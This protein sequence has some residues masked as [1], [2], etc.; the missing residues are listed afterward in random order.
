[1]KVLVT[2]SQGQLGFDVLRE[3]HSRRI[4]CQGVD[5][6]DFDITDAAA[7]DAY[8]QDYAPDVV[9]HCAAYTAV[10]RAEEDADT[11]FKV[12]Y[13]GTD[14]LAAWCGGND[15]T[16]IY[17][18]T[19]YVFSSDDQQPI[20]V[21]ARLHPLNI[22]GRSKLMGE[23]AVLRRCKKYYIV[24]TSWVFGINGG[25]FVKTM[26]R[27]AETRDTL[28]VVD[29][30]VGSPTY[31]PDLARLLCD[32]A[33]RGAYGI[34]HATNEGYCSWYEFACAI[35]REAGKTVKVLP[36]SSLDYPAKAMRPFNSR[37]D[38]QCLT[39]AGFERLPQ[40][41]DALQRF[42]TELKNSG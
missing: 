30:Q 18:S 9:I 35:M 6:A 28:T 1:M 12:N 7:V 5:M 3:L 4:P 33:E 14:N 10:D 17:I 29:D 13:T 8:L 23:A 11:C 40:W 32:M 20:G 19:D 31:T 24:R 34:Y 39:D 41:E 27:L 25:N 21:D 26:L 42:L 16:M 2:G 37:L 36:I 38:K 22:Y 15:A